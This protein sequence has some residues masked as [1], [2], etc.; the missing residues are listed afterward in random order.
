MSEFEVEV[1]LGSVQS[2]SRICPIESP[3]RN[4]YKRSNIPEH[5]DKR[6]PHFTIND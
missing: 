4:L 6:I 5:L 2:F 3:Y 1:C